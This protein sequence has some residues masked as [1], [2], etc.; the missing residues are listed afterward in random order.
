[1]I[2]RTL[3]LSFAAAMLAGG[4]QLCAQSPTPF[5]AGIS[6]VLP[7]DTLKAVTHASGLGGA[8]FEAGYN[9][10]LGKTTVPCRVSLSIN[11]L[12]GKETAYAT[13]SLL[14]FQAAGDVMIPFAPG[15]R[16]SAVAGLS[17]NGWRWNYQD[18]GQHATN[19]MKGAKFG[20]RFGFDY[21]ASDRITASLM[22]QMV[23]LGID[24]NATR[25]Y[26]PSW[27]QAGARYR[28]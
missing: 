17:L 1:M 27:I 12:P 24:A 26:N 3:I 19:S 13:S 6:L 23:E 22:L 8:T 11:D 20:A 2:T 10:T 7:L 15:S 16:L 5:D 25:G 28:F 21:Q 18:A 4:F 14:G 9:S